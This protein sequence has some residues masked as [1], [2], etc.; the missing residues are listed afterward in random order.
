MLATFSA[1]ERLQG[2]SFDADIHWL[3]R[4]ERESGRPFLMFL[5]PPSLDQRIVQQSAL[6]SMLSKPEDDLETW[7]GQYDG[8]ARRVLLP[9]ELKW[10]VR[11]RLDQANITER[12][13]FP[14]LSG[15]GQWLRLYYRVRG[16][17]VPD[18]D[19]DHTPENSRNQ[20]R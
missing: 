20:H 5:E 17:E 19:D 15:L 10:E 9:A 13:L 14:D 18:Q 3:E 16:D 4:M 8:A 12:T 7:L 2:L 6:F 11:D 1:G